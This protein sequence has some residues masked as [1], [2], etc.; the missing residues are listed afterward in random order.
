MVK[1]YDR[2][3]EV[4]R[5]TLLDTVRSSNNGRCWLSE[6]RWYEENFT[7][8]SRLEDYRKPFYRLITREED[9]EEEEDLLTNGRI[10][11]FN[12]CL[13]KKYISWQTKQSV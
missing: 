13:L 7:E 1:D 12:F 9:E 8:Q 5:K 11:S 3:E 2:R 6:L 4:Q 10:L